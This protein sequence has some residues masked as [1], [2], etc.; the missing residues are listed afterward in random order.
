MDSAVQES[1]S[2]VYT[3]LSD[4][5]PITPLP[6]SARIMSGHIARALVYLIHRAS[7]LGALDIREYLT[8][9]TSL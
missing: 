5:R 4:S 8:G 3:E 7:L 9:K 6:T 2:P 1:V